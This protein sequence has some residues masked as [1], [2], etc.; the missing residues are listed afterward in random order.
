MQ[1]RLRERNVGIFFLSLNNYL[2]KNND[3]EI[4][5]IPLM[6]KKKSPALNSILKYS[7]KKK[8]VN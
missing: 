8:S 1:I 3:R 6:N 5:C 7:F 2:I 4:D